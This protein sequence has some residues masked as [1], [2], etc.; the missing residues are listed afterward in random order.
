MKESFGFIR[1]LALLVLLFCLVAV[2]AAEIG[3]VT[4]RAT[5]GQILQDA[6]EQLVY[7]TIRCKV[8]GEFSPK[9]LT[10]DIAALYGTGHFRDIQ[11]S[12]ETGADG[13]VQVLFM[14]VPK[15]L[16]TAIEIVG[17]K[18]YKDSSLRYLLKQK[19]EVPADDKIVAADCAAIMEKYRS[20][21]YHG[22]TVS[23]NFEDSADGST[24]TLTYVIQ[25]AARAKLQGV[26]FDGNTVFEDSEIKSQLL[27]K[28]Q[29]WRYIFR[30][31]NYF[32][33]QLLH[34]DKKKISDLYATRGYLDFAVED[35]EL[36]YDEEQKWVTVVFKFYE[37]KPYTVG[38]IAIEGNSRFTAEE[39]LSKTTLASGQVYDSRLESQDITAMRREYEVLGYGELKFIPRHDSDRSTQLVDITYKVVEG[40]QSRI[41]DIVIV[42]N[43]V[44]K[45]KV[46][47]REL[48]IHADDY[49]D[50][51]RINLSKQRLQ[52]LDYFESVEMYPI[53]TPVPDLRD[54]RIELKEKST[55]TMSLG[56]GFSSEDSVMGF[57][58]FTETNFDLGR[59]FDWPPKGGGQRFRAYL[60][61][62]TDVQNVS[63]SFIEPAF[64]DR[65]LELSNDLFLNTRF[66]D[67]YDERHIG[68]AVMLSWPIAFRLPG[69]E[70]V[71][72]WRLGLGVRIEHI[73]ISDVDDPRWDDDDEHYDYI[74]YCLEDEEGGEFANR[75]ILRLSR[76]TRDQFRFPTRGSRI[77]LE[78]E[79]V[80][81]AL[82]SYSNYFRFHAGGIKYVPVVQDFVLKM[83]LDG[84]AASHLSGDDIKIFDRYFGGGYGTIRGFKRRDVSPVNYNENPIGGL[85]MLMASVELIKPVKDF[86]F[87]SLFTDIGNTWWDSFDADLGELNMSIGVGVQFKAVPIRLDYGYPV[88]TSGEYLDGKSGRFHFNIGISY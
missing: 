33:E 42:G 4:V 25:E 55:G 79:F 2:Q 68:G 61:I 18:A 64:L 34:Y 11:T 76:D 27:T 47:Q 43:E 80:T 74:N 16:V 20:G 22:T 37:G 44:T 50:L 53:A 54:L 81:S 13:K 67:D 70:Q 41:R 59:L 77:S 66:E 49:T 24:C 78:T 86:M 39:L 36:R 84:W 52:N 5:G 12:S 88:K 23:S 19:L 17:N 28:R 10:E 7:A 65:N 71:E 82:G 1:Q 45:N 87:V 40:T 83:S 58:E 48:A 6:L 14:V 69:V 8:G 51:S 30:F 35:V 46:I 73:R 26:V 63:I 31:G 29:W 32:N 72:F 62:G 21:G 56:A 85:T 38:K 15:K 75:L 3:Q 60:G 9:V 57:L